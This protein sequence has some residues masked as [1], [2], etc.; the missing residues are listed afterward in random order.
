MASQQRNLFY[1]DPEA[2]VATLADAN[3]S[4]VDRIERTF[5]EID[6]L[7]KLDPSVENATRQGRKLKALEAEI[8]KAQAADGASFREAQAI[9]KR[10]F[11]GLR[12][13]VGTRLGRISQFLDAQLQEAGRSATTV[14]IS[15]DGVAVIETRAAHIETPVAAEWQVDGVER[16]ALDLEALRYYF[17]DH[18]LLLASRK[19]LRE[20]G[21]R[22]VAGVMY[23]QHATLKTP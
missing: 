19:H 1:I 18:Q 7:A 16:D 11:D 12:A 23:R 10:Y 4:L 21:A 17:T 20:T 6:T 9:V 15:Y 2:I 13:K 3:A 8:R 22:Q 5:G 14:A